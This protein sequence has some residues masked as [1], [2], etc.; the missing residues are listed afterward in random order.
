M[1]HL[2]GEPRRYETATLIGLYATPLAAIPIANLIA[3]RLAPLAGRPKD[4]GWRNFIFA[5]RRRE[6]SE[7]YSAPSAEI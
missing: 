6:Q 5:Q 4:A 1:R 3:R 2:Y 7:A